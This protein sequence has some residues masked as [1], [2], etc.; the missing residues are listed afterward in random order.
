MAASESA[1]SV[2]VEPRPAS[3]LVPWIAWLVPVTLTVIGLIVL[4]TTRQIAYPVDAWGFRGY[5]AIFALTGA[6]V[7]AIVLAHRPGNVIGRLFIAIGVLA[8][9]Q[10][11]SEEYLAV[12]VIAAPGSLPVVEW[13]AWSMNWLWI[14]QFVI[15]I[16]F[17]LIFPDGAPDLATLAGGPRAGG[18][19]RCHRRPGR[20]LHARPADGLQARQQPD[21]IRERSAVRPRWRRSGSASWWPSCWPPGPWSSAIGALGQSNACSSDGSPSPPSSRPS[22]RRSASSSRKA[23]RRS[24]SLPSVGYPSRRAW[25]SSAITSSRSTCSSTGRWSTSP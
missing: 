13:F 7:G 10:L 16:V 11:L 6:T 3:R 14:P 18:H 24:S 25:P 2:P 17:F 8:S 4:V 21:R 5:S 20:G 23:R 1:A 22:S 12:G 19:R 9:I 15:L